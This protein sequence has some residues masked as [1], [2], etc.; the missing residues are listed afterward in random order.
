[1]VYPHEQGEAASEQKAAV[2]IPAE[3]TVRFWF[4]LARFH[5]LWGP[6]PPMTSGALP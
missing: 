3:D 1:L 4:D 6:T 5:T 2:S